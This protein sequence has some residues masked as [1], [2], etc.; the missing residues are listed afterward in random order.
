M[1]TIRLV[2][3]AREDGAD[4]WRCSTVATGLRLHIVPCVRGQL[5]DLSLIIVRIEIEVAG[6]S[7]NV[8]ASLSGVLLGI[9]INASSKCVNLLS[10]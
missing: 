3:M 10:L 4:I 6:L 1:P 5:A 9:E 2:D 7:H 8:D